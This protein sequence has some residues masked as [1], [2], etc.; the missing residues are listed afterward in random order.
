MIGFEDLV[1]YAEET[2]KLVHIASLL[3][4]ISPIHITSL[5]SDIFILLTCRVKLILFAVPT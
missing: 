3:G 5:L 4:E 1:A 2:G